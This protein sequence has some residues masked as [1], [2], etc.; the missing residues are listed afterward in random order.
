MTE[1][2]ILNY[3]MVKRYIIWGL[4]NIP[5][6]PRFNKRIHP[7]A[8]KAKPLRLNRPGSGGGRENKNNTKCE[9]E[10]HTV[11]QIKG[12]NRRFLR[13]VIQKHGI[14]PNDVKN[15]KFYDLHKECAK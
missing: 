6:L 3:Q 14:L 2:A 4:S 15:P 7:T 5:L 12:K 10:T 8:T 1:P 13:E 11:S 9:Y